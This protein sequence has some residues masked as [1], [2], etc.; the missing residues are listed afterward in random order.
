MNGAVLELTPKNLP[1][2]LLRERIQT[3]R[4]K[5]NPLDSSARQMLERFFG[6]DLSD[7]RIHHDAQAHHLTLAAGAL[8]FTT[9]TDIFFR[10]GMYQPDTLP[11][12]R[13]LTH[14]VTHVVQQ[15]TRDLGGA[16]E[17]LIGDA[18]DAFERE[19]KANERLMLAHYASLRAAAQREEC[20]ERK[21]LMLSASNGILIQRAIGLE[22]ETPVPIDKLTAAQVAQIQGYVAAA[23]AATAAGNNPMANKIAAQNVM[24]QDGTVPYGIIRAAADG[25]R[26]DADHD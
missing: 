26:V 22:I 18:E 3:A 20:V 8:A 2:S 12:L 17:V 4:G 15:A 25:F 23:Q 1:W 6:R 16:D 11:G 5:G 9:G 19:A 13:L 24:A 14:E 21:P 7:V 10:S